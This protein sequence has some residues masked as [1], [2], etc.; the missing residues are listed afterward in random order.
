MLNIPRSI[1]QSLNTKSIPGAWKFP[2]T[3]QIWKVKG[4]SSMVNW[5]AQNRTSHSPFRPLVLRRGKIE[6]SLETTDGDP[7]SDFV[8]MSSLSSACRIRHC[9]LVRP[10]FSNFASAAV[11]CRIV[12]RMFWR[13]D[14]PNDYS[15]DLS[16]RRLCYLDLINEFNYLRKMSI[17][18]YFK[19]GGW[20]EGFFVI[21]LCFLR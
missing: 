15:E 11:L 13:R 9:S 10:K 1:G 21:R 17:Y 14:P 12:V 2:Q 8:L 7:L 19:K 18:K 5:T 4:G 3:G 16:L 6:G 20:I